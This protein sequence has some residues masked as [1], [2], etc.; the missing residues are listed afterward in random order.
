MNTIRE[1]PLNVIHKLSLSRE[2]NFGH[3][4]GNVNFFLTVTV[5]ANM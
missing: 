1:F 4:N 3:L 2:S 5:D